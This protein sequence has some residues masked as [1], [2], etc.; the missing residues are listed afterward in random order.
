ME[1][2]CPSVYNVSAHVYQLSK[3]RL[4]INGLALL[5]VYGLV[6]NHYHH[7][8]YQHGHDYFM[9]KLCRAGQSLNE[10]LLTIEVV[11]RCTS[12]VNQQQDS[13]GCNTDIAAPDTIYAQYGVT[14]SSCYL[15]GYDIVIQ[16]DQ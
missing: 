12:V 10:L 5:C 9:D 16:I 14:P 8:H 1:A 4:E 11:Y 13:R 15:C 3:V 2:H 7:Y 6:L